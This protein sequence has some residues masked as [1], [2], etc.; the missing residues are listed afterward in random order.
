MNQNRFLSKVTLAAIGAQVVSLLI[1]MGVIDTG[2][3]SAINGV[4]CVGWA[5]FSPKWVGKWVE[6]KKE[7]A[8]EP[9]FYGTP[10][11]GGEGSRTPVRKPWNPS[12]SERS[13]RFDIPSAQRPRTGSGFQ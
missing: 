1:L 6:R 3:G 7:S 4:M 9:L 2:A 10:C 12:I 8:V 13:P 11:G 5:H